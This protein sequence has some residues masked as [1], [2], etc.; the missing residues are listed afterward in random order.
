[1]AET[2]GREVNGRIRKRNQSILITGES[3]SGKTEASK[4]VMRFLI[5]ASRALSGSGSGGVEPSPGGVRPTARPDQGET[6]RMF[7]SLF[8]GN[9]KLH[10]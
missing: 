7:S 10:R 3:G 4:H 5:T 9:G 1:M 2:Q 8:A 6:E